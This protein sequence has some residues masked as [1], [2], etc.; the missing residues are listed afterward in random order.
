[1]AVNLLLRRLRPARHI[2]VFAVDLHAELE[3]LT[4]S[5]GDNSANVARHARTSNASSGHRAGST[6]SAMTVS[7]IGSLDARCRATDTEQANSPGCS[8]L[9][10]SRRRLP[11]PHGSDPRS[12]PLDHAVPGFARRYRPVP[13]LTHVGPSSAI[14]VAPGLVERPGLNQL[15]PRR[16]AGIGRPRPKRWG[17]DGA[18][19]KYA[20]ETGDNRVTRAAALASP[21]ARTPMNTGFSCG[22]E[23]GAEGI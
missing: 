14:S 17:L 21:E 6:E 20:D 13:L 9:P 18:M 8:P 15:Q 3:R 12:G 22:A 2:V 16:S 23:G 10:T 1:M 19:F 5:R 11:E 4:R 7:S